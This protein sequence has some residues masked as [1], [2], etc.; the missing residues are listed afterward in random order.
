MTS[1]DVRHLA[2]KAGAAQFTIDGGGKQHA[3]Q[4]ADVAVVQDIQFEALEFLEAYRVRCRAKDAR[5][6]FR[7]H[8]RGHGREGI[9]ALDSK[10]ARVCD[11]L[12]AK[13]ILPDR[14]LWP[15]Q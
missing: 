15:S 5:R 4:P 6:M 3:V 7:V 11:H 9:R 13:R 2:Q 8:L 12:A 1:E 10:F 14:R